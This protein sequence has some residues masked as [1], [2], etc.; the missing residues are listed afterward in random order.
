MAEALN[1]LIKSVHS[2]H[3]HYQHSNTCIT[4][5][6]FIWGPKCLVF[7]QCE[8]NH[9]WLS[10]VLFIWGPNCLIF[11]QCVM[12]WLLFETSQHTKWDTTPGKEMTPGAANQIILNMN[13]NWE[14]TWRPHWPMRDL[15]EPVRLQSSAGLTCPHAAG[16]A[17]VAP[18]QRPKHVRK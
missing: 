2:L 7:I 13:V 14:L 15:S 6:L 10:K 12:C 5:K 8:L 3:V 11:I 4:E 16:T 9:V 18:L 1:Q 17:V